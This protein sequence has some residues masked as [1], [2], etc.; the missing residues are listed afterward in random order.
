[1]NRRDF[2]K[3]GAAVSVGATTLAGQDRKESKPGKIRFDHAA[4]A[5]I[6]GAGAAGLPAAIMA[7]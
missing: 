1:M 3:K 4:D 2:L 7:P 5:V 6:V